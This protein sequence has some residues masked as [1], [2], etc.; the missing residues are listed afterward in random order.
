MYGSQA[1]AWVEAYMSGLGWVRFEPTSAMENADDTTWGYRLS[2]KEEDLPELDI[3]EEEEEPET[4]KLPEPAPVQELEEDNGETVRGILVT[5]GMYL[6]V[7]LGVA[8]VLFAAYLLTRRIRYLRLKPE[9]KL[10][11]NVEHLRRRLDKKLPK[12]ERAVSVYDYLPFV[13]DEE[14]RARMEELFR[15]YYRVRFRGDPAD[16]QLIEDMRKLAYQ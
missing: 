6:L 10:K 11:E 14:L 4:P 8:A 16:P 3:P 9:D 13:E 15:A 5:V 7:I 12:G 2:E 1:H